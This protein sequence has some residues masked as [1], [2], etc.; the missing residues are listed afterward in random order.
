MRQTK[1][2]VILC[3]VALIAGGPLCTV[4]GQLPYTRTD[5]DG[6][7]SA[8]LIGAFSPVAS[9]IVV[10]VMNPTSTLLMVTAALFDKNGTRLGQYEVKLPANGA[11]DTDLLALKTKTGEP[12]V[13]NTKDP[14]VIKIVSRAAPDPKSPT[15]L[16]VWQGIMGYVIQTWE[17]YKDIRWHETVP[18]TS[19]PTIVLTKYENLELKKI[20]GQL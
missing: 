16:V 15:K 4:W 7:L 8:Y 14:V 9:G 13:P 5:Q 12:V 17:A 18:L 6:D 11:V 19:V 20:L 3:I 2:V 1:R 10:R